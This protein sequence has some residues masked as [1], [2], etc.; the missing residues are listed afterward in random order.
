MQTNSLQN[1]TRAGERSLCHLQ[2]RAFG[3]HLSESRGLEVERKE[4]GELNL[5]LNICLRPSANKYQEGKM[6]K[7]FNNYIKGLVI[8]GREVSWTSFAS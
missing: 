6:Q 5:T 3:T 1:D 8:A 4:G 7:T 2:S